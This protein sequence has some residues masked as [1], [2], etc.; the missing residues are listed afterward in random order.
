MP[1]RRFSK[2]D[3]PGIT[4]AKA[5]MC[6]F[7]LKWDR[8]TDTLNDQEKNIVIARGIEAAIRTTFKT[9]FHAWNGQILKQQTGGPIGLR[10]SGPIVKI[11]MEI[12]LRDFKEAETVRRGRK[13]SK[14]KQ[15]P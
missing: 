14:G 15:T 11:C 7:R 2:G 8:Q 13:R 1:T 9:H 10:A 6:I 4:G 12:W 5:N 3:A